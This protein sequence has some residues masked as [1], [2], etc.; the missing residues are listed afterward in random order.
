MMA[1]SWLQYYDWGDH[2]WKLVGLIGALPIC[3]ELTEL[4]ES[5][6]CRGG[7]F[8]QGYLGINC[9]RITSYHVVA[10]G[11]VIVGDSQSGGEC[12]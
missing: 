1:I 11:N 10:H 7:I 3:F 8:V 6:I 5:A 4:Q 12:F 2:R 9:R